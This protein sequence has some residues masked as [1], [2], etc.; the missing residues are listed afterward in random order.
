MSWCARALSFLLAV[1]SLH[2]A[3]GVAVMSV[4]LGSEWMKIAVVS[5][6]VPMEIALNP[7]TKRKTSVAVSMKDGERSFGSDAMIVCVKS[8]KH[9]YYYL[10]DLLGKKI[11]H[12][13]VIAYQKRFPQ[14][15][16]EAD[17]ERGT[18][19]FRHDSETLYSVEELLGMILAHAKTQAEAYT[20]QTVRDV[21][22]TT[23]VFFNQAER[24]ALVAA[25]QLGGLNVLQLMN[26]PLAVALNYGMFRR[27]EINGTVKHMMLF[28]VGA[29]ATTATIV[30][31]QIVKTK[32]R[33]YSE[34]HPQAQ[35]LGVGY[36][37]TLGGTEITFRVREY[38][39]DQFNEMKKTK[40]DVRSVPRAMGKLLKEAERVKLILS[41]NNDCY[42]QIENVMEDIDFKHKMTR[43]KL[44][45]LIDDLLPRVT[46]PVERA[47][48]TAAMSMDNIDQVILVGGGTRVPKFQELLQAFVGKELGKN[49]NADESAAM[50][51][52]YRSADISSGFKVKK[53][54]TKDAVVFP[55]DVDFTREIDAEEE[56]SEDSEATFKKIRRT[57]FS[58]INPYPQKKI[59]T[60]NKH[61]KEFTFNVNYADLDYLGETEAAWIG[62]RN[63]SSVVVKGVKEALDTNMGENIE[64][65]GVKAH[66]ALDDSGI[67]TVTNIE[68][69][70]E[71]TISVEEQEKRE[72]EWKDATDGIDWSKLGENIKSF[73][74]TDEKKEGEETAEKSEDKSKEEK[75]EKS[76]E[77]KEK[78]KK[79]K[80]DKAD[81]KDDK[82]SKKEKEKPKEPKKPK[83]E[84]V[85]VDL[86][87]EDSRNDI[88]LLTG[89]IFN[90]S[91]A[92]LEA[93]TKADND[94]IAIE[95]ALNELQGYS[96]D[97]MDKM[98]DEDFQTA[99][100]EEE[101]D[102]LSAECGKVS[103]WLDEEAGM[104]V[105]VE[106][107]QSK[108]KVLKEL[109]APILARLREHNERPE[110]LEL[111]EQSL[112]SSRHFLEKSRELI[113][114]V[115][116]KETEEPTPETIAEQESKK[117]EDEAKETSE[118]T[119]EKKDDEKPEKKEEEKPKEKKKKKKDKIPE[120][121]LF[122]EKE[123]ESL[124][125]KIAEVERWRDAKIAE[126]AEQ[127]SSQMPKL[128]VSLIKSKIQDLDGEVQFMISKA[129]MIKAERERA[130]RKAD[131]EKKKEEE[132]K[133]KKEKKEKKKKKKKAEG[134][135]EE[136]TSGKEETSADP[137]VGTEEETTSDSSD[138]KPEDNTDQTTANEEEPSDSKDSDSEPEH[139]EL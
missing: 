82:D 133:A 20:E 64:T 42:A 36:D 11:D 48:S 100:T 26:A 112:N 136:Q 39:A 13:A 66:F 128:T 54:I 122:T 74:G 121:G 87:S 55:I 63:I 131:E 51:A 8:P 32:E 57:L 84:S 15:T 126:Q 4:D 77:S 18:V 92:K 73:F 81:K 71:K 91:K 23:P 90:T 111:L 104:F 79:A 10:L 46:K 3:A 6:G 95:L 60:F 115:K 135:E 1:A 88:D 14:Y 27:K 114:P 7:Q 21:V 101:R 16:L 119:E 59:M 58:R 113:I 102:K 49:L 44:M 9:C 96:I 12:P 124:E 37:R 129:R 69:V 40:T 86:S 80:D 94:R 125:K 52:V 116:P 137:P 43:D 5:P 67:L 30:G 2:L 107:F 68:S 85:K 110:A 89:D 47:L 75:K 50:G 117:E 19:L 105:P 33:G 53:F 138:K 78:T 24:L 76:D 132:E 106:E 45:E 139:S 61:V 123:L 103:E 134:A 130:K 31:L 28:D 93:L 41:A 127:P 65:K 25:A 38:L 70:F 99:S 98:E 62:S 22:I 97:M 56:G 83:V 118:S 17:P 109:S 35:I 108:L 29:Q 34:T 120:E 72:K